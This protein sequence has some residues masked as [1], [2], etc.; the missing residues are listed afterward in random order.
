MLDLSI[1]QNYPVLDF[2]SN[3]NFIKDLKKIK[4]YEEFSSEN[5]DF[6]AKKYYNNTGYWWIIALYNDIVN[7]FNVDKNKI[8]KIPE[9]FEVES[10]FMDYVLKAKNET[11]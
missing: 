5:L 4:N 1:F 7:P 8:L 9:L 6:L 2:L 11:N 3:Q 10:L